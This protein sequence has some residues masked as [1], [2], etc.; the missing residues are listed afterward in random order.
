VSFAQWNAAA[1]VAAAVA[2]SALIWVAVWQ[3]L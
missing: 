3:L 1:R 2:V